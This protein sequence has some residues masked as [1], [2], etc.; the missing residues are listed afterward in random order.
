MDCSMPGFLVLHHFLEFAQTYVHWVDDAIQPS[1][2]VVPFASCL[3]SF[4]ATGSFLISRLFPSGGQSIG[5]SDSTLSP[6]N[7]YSG[8]I[9]FRIDW[10]DLLAVQGTLKSL[11]QHHSMKASILQWTLQLYRQH[12]FHPSLFHWVAMKMLLAPR[13]GEWKLLHLSQ[14]VKS[15]HLCPGV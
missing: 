5:A 6:S 2:P 9:S 8:L 1:H 3:Q 13:E 4:P 7:E 10:F 11:L 14:P 15:H 12:P